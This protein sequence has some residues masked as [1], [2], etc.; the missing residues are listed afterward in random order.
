MILSLTIYSREFNSLFFL[1]ETLKL[2]GVFHRN[3]L[4]MTVRLVVYYKSLK[5]DMVRKLVGLLLLNTIFLIPKDLNLFFFSVLLKV[6][7][8]IGSKRYIQQ[9]TLILIVPH[10]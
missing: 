2:G 1:K 5:M 3:D 4:D 6:L 10:C 9:I 7:L 8:K